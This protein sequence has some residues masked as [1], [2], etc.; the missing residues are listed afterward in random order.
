MVFTVIRK[1]KN[2]P[3]GLLAML[4]RGES[5]VRSGR[6]RGR[7]ASPVNRHE[8]VPL[9]ALRMPHSLPF[10]ARATGREDRGN[11]K[12]SEPLPESSAVLA[13]LLGEDSGEEARERLS[14]AR[15]VLTADLTL[16]ECDRVLHRAAF[17]GDMSEADAARTRVLADTAAEHWVVFSIEGE[18][19]GRARRA[20][21]RGAHQDARCH[22]SRDGAGEPQPRDGSANPVVG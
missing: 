2:R 15:L 22:S 19:V 1:L 18:M 12:P 14:S 10:R 4:R 17:L 8:A 9:Y 16:I 6:S 5:L 13:W 7:V 3:G 11:G 20:F 21:P